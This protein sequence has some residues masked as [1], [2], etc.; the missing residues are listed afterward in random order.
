[1]RVP[2]VDPANGHA[3]EEA[4]QQARRRLAETEQ[5]QDA[6]AADLARAMRRRP[7]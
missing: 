2:P 5:Q 1:M 4:L 7:V 6:F 3:T